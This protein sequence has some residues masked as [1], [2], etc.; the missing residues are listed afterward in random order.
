MTDHK[1][2]PSKGPVPPP[3]ELHCAESGMATKR[4]EKQKTDRR[5]MK[6]NTNKTGTIEK[7]TEKGRKSSET[8]LIGYYRE[9]SNGKSE[10][11]W[12]YKNGRPN[13][14][15]LLHKK[16]SATTINCKQLPSASIKRRKTI[17]EQYTYFSFFPLSTSPYISFTSCFFFGC[18][19]CSVLA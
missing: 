3:V 14:A 13:K 6:R 10:I 19:T 4:N 17:V 7:G 5:T 9:G 8:T 2:W 15:T 11:A 1:F 12:K 16:K 18:K